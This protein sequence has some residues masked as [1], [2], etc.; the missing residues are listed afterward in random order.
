MAKVVSSYDPTVLVIFGV[1]GDLSKRYLLPAL[2]HLCKDGLLPQPC[3]IIGTSRQ[4]LA[5]DD[6]LGQVELCV[7]EQ[8]NICDPVVLDNLRRMMELCQLEPTS[9]P[10]YQRLADRLNT[11]EEKL[12]VCLNRLFYLSIPPQ[13]YSGVV[14]R[15]G[16]AKLNGSCQHGKA[17]T[18][19]MVEKPFGYD[20]A[21]A[22]ELIAATAAVFSEE[23]TYRIDHY[24]AKETVQNI[25]LFRQKNPDLEARWNG[26]HISRIEIT[27]YE[28]VD[29]GSRRFYDAIG[30]LRDII[31]SHL[32]Q[33][34]G[35][36]IMELP[37]PLASGSIHNS[38]AR[39]LQAIGAFPAEQ[40]AKATVRAQYEGY[41]EEVG[42]PESTTETFATVRFQ[43]TAAWQG[44]EVFLATGKALNAKR[45]EIN[46]YFRGGSQVQFRVQPQP[47]IE[48][49]KLDAVTD[50][51]NQQ[52]P[53]NHA[54]PDAYERVLI[55]AIRGDRTLFASADEVLASWH[56]LQPVLSEWSKNQPP[57]Q[58]YAKGSAPAQL[59][60]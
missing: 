49:K 34:L 23:Q 36:C 5:L 54:E 48:L 14:K 53:L 46:V 55:D 24:L 9:E 47:R 44:T 51:S 27:A 43:L 22:R 3:R 1:T 33:L 20:L 31:Q 52:S 2:Y 15:L 6:F 7:L 17:V 29:V 30:A 25:L 26:Q 41:K 60:S 4:K 56:S 35:L 19:L 59:L 12:G 11:L 57:L 21:S 50:F 37:H 18:R 16:E 39:A 45:T 13:L 40:V 58:T 8:D 38:K 10:D 32:W 42:N 28:K